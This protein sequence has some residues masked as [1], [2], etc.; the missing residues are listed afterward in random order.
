MQIS[1]D[2]KSY[3]EFGEF[4]IHKENKTN[5]KRE[6]KTS[7]NRLSGA[8]TRTSIQITKLFSSLSIK[9]IV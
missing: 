6:R 5:M 9:E 1:Y 4:V 7:I 3:N 2:K 8:D